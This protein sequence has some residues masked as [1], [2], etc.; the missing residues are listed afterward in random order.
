MIRP[1]GLALIISV[2]YDIRAMALLHQMVQRGANNDA[3]IREAET[4]LPTVGFAPPGPE[5]TKSASW[6]ALARHG[7]GQPAKIRQEATPNPCASANG[8]MVVATGAS[9]SYFPALKNLVASLHYWE[10]RALIAVVSLG[11]STA[12]YDT[13][14]RWD[15]VCMHSGS[16][17]ELKKY[18]WKPIAIRKFVDLYGTVLW[19]DAGSSVR[20]P[21]ASIRQYLTNDGHFLVQGQD[22]DMKPWCHEGTLSYFKVN[23]ARLRAGP[24][25][26]GNLQGWV[27]NSTL[28]RRVL[29]GTYSC[30][31]R[32]ECIAPRGSNLGNHR[33]DQSVLSLLAY[34]CGLN[35]TAHTEL[36]AANRNQLSTD[37]RLPSKM[38]VWTSRRAD[39][40][41]AHLGGLPRLVSGS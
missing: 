41:Y 21:L 8:D 1:G 34:T 39:H 4:A 38:V 30:A 2:V 17:I 37:P 5:T 20:G 22:V 7:S 32:P 40:E 13:A 18:A 9:D 28:A 11:L 33:Y 23:R 31:L 25:Y 14:S 12:N 6:S 29:E 19:I 26:S 36:L 27:R 10:P 24:S 16:E 15:N 35:I 3:I